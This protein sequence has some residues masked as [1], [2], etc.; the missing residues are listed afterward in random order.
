MNGNVLLLSVLLF[1]TLFLE[2]LIIDDS[3]SLKWKEKKNTYVDCII[4]YIAMPLTHW[5]CR[6]IGSS[7]TNLTIIIIRVLLIN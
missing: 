6:N 1:N 2:L 5:K 7:I 4:K 3:M